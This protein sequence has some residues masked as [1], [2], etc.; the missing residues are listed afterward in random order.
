MANLTLINNVNND[1]EKTKEIAIK[2]NSK[3]NQKVGEAANK[4]E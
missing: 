4:Q 1:D 2:D 3:H